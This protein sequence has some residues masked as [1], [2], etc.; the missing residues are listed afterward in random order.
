MKQY[1]IYKEGLLGGKT[2]TTKRVLGKTLLEIIA[3]NKIDEIKGFNFNNRLISNNL[4]Y[5]NVLMLEM[6]IKDY[7]NDHKAK[8]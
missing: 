3:L 6:L 4:N 7:Q 8:R 5:V 2:M 1:S